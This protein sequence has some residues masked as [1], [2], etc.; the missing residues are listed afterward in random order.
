MKNSFFNILKYFSVVLIVLL[1]TLSSYANRCASFKSYE[2]ADGLPSDYISC[3]FQDSQGFVWIGTNN[4]VVR[5]DGHTFLN[6]RNNPLDTTTI[7]GNNISSVLEN[8]NGVLLVGTKDHGLS[9]WE[10]EKNE[11]HQFVNKSI[12]SNDTI[13]NLFSLSNGN[14]LVA[15]ANKIVINSMDSINGSSFSLPTKWCF[16]VNQSAPI[17]DASKTGFLL[18][19]SGNKIVRYNINNKSFDV[20]EDGNSL[21]GCITA[22]ANFSKDLYVI[23]TNYGLFFAQISDRK[24]KVIKRLS[25][26]SVTSLLKGSNGSFWVGSQM[27]IHS[28]DAAGNLSQLNSCSQQI[29]STILQGVTCLME[30]A[31]GLLWAGTSNSGLFKI[32]LSTPKFTTIISSE[33]YNEGGLSAHA[34]MAMAKTD[35]NKLLI[36]NDIGEVFL[37]DENLLKIEP[38]KISNIELLANREILSFLQISTGEL[39]IGTNSGLFVVD[40]ATRRAQLV[41]QLNAKAQLLCAVNSIVLGGK[42]EVWLATS[43][44]LAKYGFGVLSF[45]DNNAFEITSLDVDDLNNLW[46]G[47]LKGLFLVESSSQSMSKLEGITAVERKLLSFPILSMAHD[48]L[49]KL[50]LGTQSGLIL[51]NKVNLS[52]AQFHSPDKALANELICSVVFDSSNQAWVGTHK[53]LFLIKTDGEVFAFG[54][55]DGIDLNNISPRASVGLASG[56]IYFGGDNGLAFVDL[57]RFGKSSVKHKM[58]I[59]SIKWSTSGEEQKC[60]YG[61]A[62][63]LSIRGGSELLIQFELAKLDLSKPLKNRYK[64]RINGAGHDWTNLG[65][66][67]VATFYDLAAGDYKVEV[68]GSTSDGVFADT[69]LVF[70]LTIIP[71]LFKSGFAFVFYILALLFVGQM[72]YNYGFRY[73]RII[74]R[75]LNA[76]MNSKKLFEKQ[77][78]NLA[79]INKNLTDS[80][81]YA[82]RIQVAMLPTEQEI[83]TILPNS[84]VYFQPK[85]VVSG[86]FYAVFEK[87]DQIVVVAADCT[88]HGVPGAF[89]SMI[90]YDMVKN[91]VNIQNVVDPATILTLINNEVVSMLHHRGAEGVSDEQDVND[92]MDMTICVIDKGLKSLR[93][94]GAINSLYLIRN[95]EI[96]TYKGSRFSVGHKRID[97][98]IVFST[99]TVELEADD[100]CYMFS[101][102][103]VDQFGGLESKKFKFR[104]FRHLLLQIHRLAYEAQQVALTNVMKEWMEKGNHVQVDDMLVFGFKIGRRR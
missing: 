69:P 12:S 31:T 87:D 103:Y 89:M 80:I 61:K 34:I 38:F 88:G 73:L 3:L 85:D 66:N 36:G 98:E 27:G 40:I 74:K 35:N 63:S 104:R 62:E 48:C 19:G 29:T 75:S 70:Y 41:Q 21:E 30:D 43:H 9:Y 60:Y 4:G 1:S 55:E 65:A 8:R 25:N 17:F 22:I 78:V 100:A 51:L 94:A 13:T 59:S 54:E 14:I 28:L 49:G 33:S 2:V 42:G 67:N 68:L 79:L 95:N 92:G 7:S 86:D 37:S 26:N 83:R 64:V 5:F 77:S 57:N 53:G 71:P 47:S 56:K 46:V 52:V 16:D 11:Y 23:G 101:D 90:G 96:H 39:L 97:D 32:D 18:I 45:F 24:F 93:F 50:W 102:G 82:Q 10:S 99:Q 81:D 72:V 76:E 84:F 44:G 6:S 20:L 58:A 91:I 15:T